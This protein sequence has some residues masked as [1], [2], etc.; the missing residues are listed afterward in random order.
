MLGIIRQGTES[1]MAGIIMLF[2]KSGVK[3]SH[4]EY[5]V[6]FGAPCLKKDAFLDSSNNL[7]HSLPQVVLV[8][9]ISTGDFKRGGGEMING[10]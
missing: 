3:K 10:P 9:I 4:L 2:Y 6:Q 7:C 1:K 5:C 8:D